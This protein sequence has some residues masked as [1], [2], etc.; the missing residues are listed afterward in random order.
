MQHTIVL[1]TFVWI[2][3]SIGA[4]V[5]R[6]KQKLGTSTSRNQSVGTDILVVGRDVAQHGCGIPSCQYINLARRTDRRKQVEQELRHA[7]QPCERVEA[8][9]A[10]S[11]HVR[12]QE[13]CRRSHLMALDRIEASGQPYG[14]VLEDDM[15]WQQENGTLQEMFCHIGKMIDKYPVILLACVGDGFSVG[16]Q[17]DL[18]FHHVDKCQTSSAY[19][20]RRDYIKILRKQWEKESHEYLQAV[21]Q[22]WKPLQLRDRWLMTWPLLVKQRPSWSDIEGRYVDYKASL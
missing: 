11:A 12:P 14:L 7:G 22:I 8:V 9:D 3:P 1:L 5:R 2:A 6:S 19:V 15:M 21:D 10:K 16:G 13:A 4:R 20:I 18:H 17:Q